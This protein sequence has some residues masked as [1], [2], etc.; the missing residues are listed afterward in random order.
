MSCMSQ[1]YMYQSSKMLWESLLFNW[2]S[3]C[4]CIVS[5]QNKYSITRDGLFEFSYKEPCLIL[6]YAQHVWHLNILPSEQ[7]YSISFIGILEHSWVLLV[8]NVFSFV[9]HI[10]HFICCCL[11]LWWFWFHYFPDWNNNIHYRIIFS[12]NVHDIN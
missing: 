1:Q 10:L 11:I 12:V 8:M 3:T 6:L 7:W 4:F 5:L 9:D 2:F